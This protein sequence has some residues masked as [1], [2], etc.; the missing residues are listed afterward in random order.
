M[1]SISKVRLKFEEEIESN[2]Q[3]RKKGRKRKNT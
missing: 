1:G 2:E 3:K